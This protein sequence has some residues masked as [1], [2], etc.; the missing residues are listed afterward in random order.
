MLNDPDRR[1]A[2][3]G[4]IDSFCAARQQAFLLKS[5]VDLPDSLLQSLHHTAPE[6]SDLRLHHVSALTRDVL[7]VRPS[8]V[9]PLVGRGTFHLLYRVVLPSGMCYIVRTSHLSPWRAFDFYID[10]WA[11]SVL[12]SDA[13]PV[14][15][16]HGVDVSRSCYPF[17]YEVLDEA[18]GRSLAECATDP[19]K[20]ARVLCALGK[21]IGHL[22]SVKTQGFGLLDVRHIFTHR[23]GRGLVDSWSEYLCCNLDRHIH[24]CVQHGAISAEEAGIIA[25]AFEKS[26]PAWGTVSP[27]LLH[28]DLNNHN[29]FTDGE[30]ITALFDW[31]DC[32]S[33]DPAFDIATWGTFIGNDARRADFLDGYCSVRS[34]AEDFELR[35]RL[36]YLRMVLAKTV[37]RFR[38][39]Y[40]RG[41]RIPP[42][43]RIRGALQ[44]VERIL[45]RIA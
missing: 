34:I 23:Q 1:H 28:G 12:D 38:F 17:D 10:Q 44:A 2:L 13:L 31:E 37:H 18:R 36:Y 32:L 27:S 16:V 42:S 6:D 25:S 45:S 20:H 33:G 41:D 29:V 9:V 14:L 30:R 3:R 40:Q 11:M 21:I 26:R 19:S 43:T 5:D 8:S 4:A 15:R 7:G 35:Y 39:G 22:H 24:A